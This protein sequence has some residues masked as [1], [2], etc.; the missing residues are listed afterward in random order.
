MSNNKEAA[1]TKA[2][3]RMDCLSTDLKLRVLL[4]EPFLVD[5]TAECML[6]QITSVRASMDAL[7]EVLKQEIDKKGSDPESKTGMHWLM[8][9]PTYSH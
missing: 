7:E 3:M 4:Q 5:G 2:F 9:H 1:F 6:N 8:Q